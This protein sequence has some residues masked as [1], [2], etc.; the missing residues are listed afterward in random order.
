MYD[1]NN[2]NNY[3]NGMFYA[4]S[5]ALNRKFDVLSGAT[6]MTCDVLSGQQKWHGMFC[7]GCQKLHGMFCLVRQ[8]DVGCLS[9]MS[10]KGTGYF[11]RDVL[12]YIPLFCISCAA[13]CGR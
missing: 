13:L 1:I 8:I 7:P 2:S 5:Y 3:Q 10:K 11:G 6:K 12:S 9:G 4:L